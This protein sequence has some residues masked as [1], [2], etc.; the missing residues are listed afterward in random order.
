[1]SALP[2]PF[3]VFVAG[4]L[5]FL[6]PC[7][8][9]LVPGYVS[10]ISGV[11]VQELTRRRGRYWHSV[12]L[13]SLIFI[14]GFSIV[15]ISLGALASTVGRVIGHN[16]TLFN[17]IA[18]LI[19]IV[20][21]LHQ[22]GLIP[23]KP[24]Y[25]DKR[26]HIAGS[27]SPSRTFLIGLSFAFGWTPCVGPILAA[28]LALAASESTLGRGIVLL[29]IYSLGLAVPFFLTS[30]A[31]EHF[32]SFYRRFRPYLHAVEVGAG[33]L[34]VIMGT[35]VFTRQVVLINS[36]LSRMPIFKTFAERFL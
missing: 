19:I 22:S 8:L 4:L 7:V 14:L 32:L 3:A 36:W 15:F 28:I 26:F 10:V 29:S 24:L 11:G 35:L 23:I 16:L 33:L 17:E 2:L 27:I 13:N 25:A 21:G 12:M 6:S 1:M 9:P 18:G 5:S 20:F 31:V 30:L 34:L